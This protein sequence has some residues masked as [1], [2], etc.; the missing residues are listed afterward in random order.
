MLDLEERA[1]RLNYELTKTQK[2]IWAATYYYDPGISRIDYGEGH[3]MVLRRIMMDQCLV[4]S[5]GLLKD[6]SR[7]LTRPE[8]PLVFHDQKY[9]DLLCNL[10]PAGISATTISNELPRSMTSAPCAARTAP[11]RTPTLSSTTS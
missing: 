3:V 10:T 7:L 11:A 6:M 9:V 5:Y 2:E 1:S 4:A 8:E